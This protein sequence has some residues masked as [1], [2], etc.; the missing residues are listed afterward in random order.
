MSRILMRLTTAAIL[1]HRA[2]TALCGLHMAY[3]HSM[4]AETD[5]TALLQ[6]VLFHYNGPQQD[7]P[8]NIRACTKQRIKSLFIKIIYTASIGTL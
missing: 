6:T 1:Q 8:H 4:F 3:T 7:T 2:I 5:A